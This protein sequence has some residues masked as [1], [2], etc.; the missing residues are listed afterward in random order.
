M[1]RTPWALLSTLL[2]LWCAC[3]TACAQPAAPDLTIPEWRLVMP[4]PGQPQLACFD[5]EGIRQILRVQEHARHALRLTELHLALQERTQ[6]LIAEM[7]GAQ[8]EYRALRDVISERNTT[9]SEELIRAQAETERYR[10]RLERRRI[11]PWVTL[12][13]GTVAGLTTG[14]GVMR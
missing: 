10:G 5:Q 6:A 11:W 2:L 9:L 1:T 3:D 12:A 14:I 4:A 7:E 8:R 13:I